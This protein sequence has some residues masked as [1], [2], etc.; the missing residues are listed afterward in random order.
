MTS[1]ENIAVRLCRIDHA[2]MVH[3]YT[4]APPEE[5]YTVLPLFVRPSV[6]LRLF[7]SHFSQQLLMAE[8]G[9]LVTSFILI[10]NIVGSVFEPV[11]FLLPVCRLSW[12]LCTLNIYAGV[13]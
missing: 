5:G 4:P 1:K 8:I 13:S 11:R 9:Y 7:S 10:C 2:M 6:R 3:N 12:F